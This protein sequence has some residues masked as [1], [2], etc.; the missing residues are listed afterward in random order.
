VPGQWPVREDINELETIGVYP[1]VL[2]SFI[3]KL[4][5]LLYDKLV[6]FFCFYFSIL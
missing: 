3:I 5:S 6:L 2:G 1:Y 4:M